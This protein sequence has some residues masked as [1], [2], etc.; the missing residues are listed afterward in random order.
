[1]WFLLPGDWH[2]AETGQTGG[3][4]KAGLSALDSVKNIF[5]ARVIDDSGNFD[6]RSGS[7]T[8]IPVGDP[9]RMDGN[10]EMERDDREPGMG[11][12]GQKH[13]L[14]VLMWGDP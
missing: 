4:R 12:V 10:I 9:K 14:P 5:M 2:A 8:A 7:T 11:T 13:K 1:M 3:G 6:F